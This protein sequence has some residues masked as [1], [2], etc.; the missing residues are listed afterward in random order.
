YDSTLRHPTQIY[1]A[2]ASFVIF[3]ILMRLKGRGHFPGFLMFLYVGLYSVARFFIEIFR[4]VPR[5]IGPLSI[6]QVVSIILAVGSFLCISL[7]SDRGVSVD[8][9]VNTSSR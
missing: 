2:L 5:F 4:D 3:V 9:G 8:G 1:A 6:A 7:L